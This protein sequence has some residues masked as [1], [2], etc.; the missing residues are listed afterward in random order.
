MVKGYIH[1]I[2]TCGTVDGPGLRYVIFLQGCP[3]RCQYC[4][5]P[6]TWEPG[7]GD[8]MTVDEVLRSFYNNTAFYRNGGVTVTGGE[9]MMQMDFLIEL[10]TKLRK[11]GVHTCLDSSGIMFRPNSPEFMEKMEKLAEVT[12]LVM[13]DIKHIDDEKHKDLTSHSNKNILAFA[14][15]L[16]EKKIPVWIR[17]VIVPGITLYR[18]YLERLGE[19]MGTLNNVK[20]LDVLP[21]HSMGKVKYENLNMEY[22][23]KDTRE[24]TKDEAIAAKHIILRAYKK[25][26]FQKN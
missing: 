18:D 21:Y 26:H 4:H 19:F 13:L 10:F 2:E 20:A 16:D 8:E 6:D 24:A 12:S 23:L 11:D 14:R 15:Y 3:M 1:S 7:K 17:H 25:S 9:P 5:N 22:P